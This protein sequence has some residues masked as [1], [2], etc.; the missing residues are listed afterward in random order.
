MAVD[1]NSEE[2]RLIRRLIPLSTMSARQF[3]NLCEQIQIESAE[4]GEYLFKRGDNDSRLYYLLEGSV[5]LQTEAFTV[6]T[7]RADSESARFAIAH[8]IPRKIHAVANGRIRFLR[9]NA[10]MVQ[11]SEVTPYQEN[12]ST[13]MVE[14]LEDGDD[15]MTTLLRSPVF[16]S[17]PPANL[18]RV[19]MSLEEIHLKPGETVIRQGEAGDY[20]YIIKK[21]QALISR[22]PSPNAKEIK[23]AQLGDLDSF[24]E[25]ALISGEPRNVSVTALTDLTLLRLGKEQFID[26]IK[27]PTL[28]Y[29]GIEELDQQIKNGAKLID[30]RNPDEY[31]SYHL[32]HSVNVPFFSL[33]MYLK[34]LHRHHPIIVVCKDGRTSESAAFILHRFKFNAFVL[35][36]GMSSVKPGELSSKPA[37]FTIDDGTETGNSF[38]PSSEIISNLSE[39]SG[40]EQKQN[41][42]LSQ[43]VRQLKA[44]CNE[45]VAEKKALELKCAALS[46]QIEQLKA[47]MAVLKM[48]SGG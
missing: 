4:P 36:G 31:K 39:H 44:R 12:T 30:V 40:P 38:V 24:G 45:L 33:R 47:E 27:K 2:A 19:L 21:G 34:S 6:E 11:S 14:E 32:P 41:A 37:T 26:L 3:S 42:D 46:R 18:Q 48:K 5:N 15:W 1:I 28:K 13:M 16:R 17:L 29:I 9:L 7:I 25:D 43:V 35:K 10:N 20:Y 8:Q 22:R 23:L